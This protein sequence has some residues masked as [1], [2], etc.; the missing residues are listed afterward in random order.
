MEEAYRLL[1]FV[2]E[3]QSRN[4]NDTVQPPLMF[5]AQDLGSVSVKEV[6]KVLYRW[7]FCLD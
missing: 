3:L 7:K 6:N 1:G 2:T 4:A 5:L